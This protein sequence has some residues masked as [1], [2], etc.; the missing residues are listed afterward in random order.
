MAD[1]HAEKASMGDETGSFM[2]NRRLFI[3]LAGAAGGTALASGAATAQSA[4][5]MLEDVEL[6][7][8]DERPLVRLVQTGGTIASTEEAADEG[9]SLSEEA[10]AIVESVPELE[11]FVDIEIVE[12]AQKGSPSLLVEDYVSVA[13]AAK[14]AEEDGAAG[15]I[16]THG[17]NTIEEDA[18]FNDLVLDLDIP[19]VFVGAMRPADAIVADGPSNLL[20]AA[21]LVTRNEFHLSDEPSGVYALLNETVH[22]ARDIMK[23][24]TWSLETFS[25]GSP[26]PIA[27]FTDDEILI[28]REPGSYSSN[29]S[30]CDLEATPERTVPIVATGAGAEAPLMEQAVNGKYD[31]DGF[32]VQHSGRGGTSPAISDAVEATL[33]AGIPVVSSTRNFDGPASPSDEEGTDVSMEDLP[34][35]KARI[36]LIVALTMTSDL[37]EIRETVEAGKYG[38]AIVPTSTL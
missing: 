17:T 21:R 24:D 31:A 8:E 32:A 35:W 18:Y 34:V 30:D 29:L 15:V 27:R 9:Y 10:D 22:A 25:S 7:D 2:P 36:H 1:K 28:Y 33:D 23:S 16:V 19:V 6:P 26:G 37:E 5:E 20:L 12:A 4:E 11:H 14:Q 13:K 38:T 3:Q